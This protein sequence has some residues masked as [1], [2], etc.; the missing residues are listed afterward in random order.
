MEK[1]PIVINQPGASRGRNSGL[2]S[3]EEP[4]SKAATPLGPRAALTEASEP[5]SE[6]V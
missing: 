1:A 6:S 5:G 4:T 3:H 2:L